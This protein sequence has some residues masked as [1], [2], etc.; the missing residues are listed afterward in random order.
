M[1]SWGICRTAAF[2]ATPAQNL[3]TG[4]GA[5]QVLYNLAEALLDP[6]D[7]I[8]FPT[9]YWTSYVDIADILGAKTALLPCPPEQNY[10]LTPAQLEQA[11]ASK[12]KVF[13]FNNPSNPTGM[14]YTRDEI[15]ALAEVLRQASGHL[16]H[17][18]RHLQPHGVRRRRLPQLR[19]DQAGT[20]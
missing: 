13:L 14:V 17:L 8:V 19:A 20:A 16:D 5:K 6:G 7:E 11:L 18:R 9:P 3:A 15:A 10:K 1:R 12:P 2:P 4:I